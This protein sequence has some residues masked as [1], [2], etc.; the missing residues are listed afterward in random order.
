MSPFS[1]PAS[2]TGQKTVDSRRRKPA[3]HVCLQQED[4]QYDTFSLAPHGSVVLVP[5]NLD[6]VLGGLLTEPV[7]DC[8]S[9]SLILLS[10]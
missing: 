4:P 1:L 9:Q 10:V 8:V 7:A 6:A 3:V 2:D 5:V